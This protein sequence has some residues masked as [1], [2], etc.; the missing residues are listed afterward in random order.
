MY[1]AKCMSE[2]VK[3][4]T[5]SLGE[6]A[7]IYYSVVSPN[8]MRETIE[9][10]RWASCNCFLRDNVIDDRF[11]VLPYE[12]ESIFIIRKGD[13]IIKR[14]TPQYVNYIE[15]IE[16]EVFVGNNLIIARAK[17]GV[18]PK[19]L[20]MWL[21]ENIASFATESS[22]GAVMKSVS[23]TDLERMEIRLPEYDKQVLLGNLW[24]DNIELY[25]LKT[26]LAKKEKEKL[27]YILK[28]Q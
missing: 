23:R 18:Y 7:D 10:C 21:N 9:R 15:K 17:E 25:K 26:E 2:N 8:K 24:F 3:M 28:K 22:T 13:V 4:P 1:N 11:D 16:K 20:A 12:G 27:N 6:I 14:I 19:Y 5:K